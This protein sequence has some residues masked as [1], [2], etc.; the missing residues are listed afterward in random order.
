MLPIKFFSVPFDEH[1]LTLTILRVAIILLLAVGNANVAFAQENFE[2][3]VIVVGDP[4][5]TTNG[6][7]GVIEAVRNYV[8]SDDQNT[9]I[10]IL[11]D[12]IYPKGL[13]NEEDKNYP[14]S[15]T[16]L[17]AVLTPFKDH[18][19]KV[20]VV[21]G[22][23]DWQRG[24]KDGWQSVKRQQRFVKQLNLPNTLFI[25][26]N[27]CPGPEEIQLTEDLVMIIMD[28]QWWL[29]QY[30]K[31]GIADDCDCK[32]EDDVIKKL[33]DIA[34][35]NQG[36]KILFAS[37]HP[38]RSN[39][40][41]GGYYTLKQHFFPATDAAPNAYV[42][43]P[44][45][46]SL[47]PLIR[48]TFGNIEDLMH[49]VYKDMIQRIEGAFSEAGSVTYAGGHEHNLQLIVEGSR[50]HLVSGSG[51]NRSRVKRGK[52]S[53]YASDENG[54][55]EILYF[56][57]KQQ[58]IRFHVVIGEECKQTFQYDVKITPSSD[59]VTAANS[60]RN[61]PDSVTVPIAPGYDAVGTGHRK[62]FGEH[63]R[64]VWATPVKM[65][66]FRLD[67]EKGG[68]K[69]LRKG[70]GQQTKSLR[71]E[72]KD[73]RQWV[74]RTIQKDPEQALPPN[75]RATIAKSII[76]D[77]ISAANPYAPLTVPILASTLKVPYAN[78]QI[79]FVPNDPAL[80]IYR[81]EFANTVCVFEEREPGVGETISTDKVREK[82]EEDNDNVVDQ[83]AVLRARMLDLLIGDWDRHEDQ[84]RWQVTKAKKK[85]IYSP[86]PRDRD[87]VFYISTGIIPSI[88]S[89]KWIM[90][91]FQGFSDHVRDVNGF[92]FNARYFD[93][94][95]L[96]ELGIKDWQEVI[97]DIQSSVTDHVIE[98]SVRQFPDTVFALVGDRIIHDLKARRNALVSEGLK[99]YRFLAEGIDVVASDKREYFHI[100][101]QPNG[102]AMITLQKLK[103]DSG[104]GDT[105]YQRLI[106]NNITKEVRLY[107]RGG[108]DVFVVDGFAKPGFKVRMIGGGGVDSFKIN[109]SVGAPRRLLIYDRSNKK[110]F[111]PKHGARLLT[112]ANDEVNEYNPRT[113]RYNKLA[114][115][116][117]IAFNLDDGL[118]LG[119]GGVFTKYGFRREPFASRHRL[120]IGH[121]LATNASFVRYRGDIT[122]VIGKAS[123]DMY[124]N[125][126]A[127][128][129]T[130]NFFGV[131][132]ETKFMS[133][134]NPEI[135]YYRTRYDFIDMQARLKFPFSKTFNLFAGPAMQYFSMSSNDNAGRFINTYVAAENNPGLFAHKAFAGGVAGFEVD[136]R[137]DPMIPVRGFFWRTSLTGMDE[138]NG[139]NSFGQIRSEMSMY[140]SFSRYPK[141]VIA[142]RIMG[143]WSLGT[144]QFFQM[145]YMG[146]DGGLLGYRKNRF[147]G[148][149][150]AYNNLELRMKLFDFKSFL[151]PGAVGLV[152]FNDVGRVWLE[153]ENSQ[154]WHWGY[155]GGFYMIPAQTI[156][157]TTVAG[158]SE[159]G[160]LPYI[161][162]GFRF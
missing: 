139:T 120:M 138:I 16:V 3:R 84:W 107:G 62:F 40:P 131:G 141:F 64:K 93:R 85:K 44:L 28:T 23:H 14:A 152:G 4:G 159:E 137:N 67:R 148:N 27:G 121:A 42:P 106:S 33:R 74:L 157:L 86:I 54:F 115:L 98:L 48:G 36:K 124:L 79:L 114:P 55:A 11:G 35:R 149:A 122:N 142:N 31:P 66:V 151:F 41:H 8:S 57:D 47:Y 51:T 160:T 50:N 134:T 101:T 7:N 18:K 100:A 77:Q 111:Y 34:Y 39:G 108:E 70:G 104:P 129:N 10:L 119:G 105:I 45:I 61:F 53:L 90:P 125:V 1:D 2:A 75:L 127:P 83:R 97:A 116:A 95:F 88:A 12:N 56:A 19:S 52:N 103:K 73:G 140:L 78:P 133:V 156:V 130:S 29:H 69:I 80:G 145:F 92:M 118:L 43:M 153:N 6:K 38:L 110:N 24:G 32:T 49:P 60:S 94:S 20:Y 96:N 21:P 5:R 158:F 9:S 89:R 26:E 68:L 113:F 65:K 150:I 162:L 46:G 22:N 87:Q 161:N 30:E 123:L 82:L 128:D 99:Y 72:D 13:P 136:T 76:Q 117:T 91:K 143:G 81:S 58:I 25:P 109:K 132:N 71:L 135:R 144:P 63:Y 147:A 59:K 154:L 102:D 155:G 126:S 112:S 146:G 15:A 17:A 37:H